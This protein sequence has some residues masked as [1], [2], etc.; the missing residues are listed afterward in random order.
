MHKCYTLGPDSSK[1]HFGRRDRD[2]LD[3]FHLSFCFVSPAGSRTI[4][5]V[6]HIQITKETQT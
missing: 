4:R 1:I 5:T 2:I 3:V 6:V